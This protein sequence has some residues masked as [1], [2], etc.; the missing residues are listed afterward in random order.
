FAEKVLWV[1]VGV[2]SQESGVR[3]NRN[4]RGGR[5]KNSKSGFSAIIYRKCSLF[6]QDQPKSRYFFQ[7]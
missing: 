1:R 2:R 4:Y 6:R 5:R 7:T 3:R